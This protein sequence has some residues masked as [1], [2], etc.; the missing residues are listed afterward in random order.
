MKETFQ[1]DPRSL[2]AFRAGIG[3]FIL[4]DL[5]KRAATLEADYTN[6]GIVPSH[7]FGSVIRRLP[8]SFHVFAQTSGE[9]AVLS[10]LAGLLAI[11]LIIGWQTRL[12]SWLSF[13]FMISLQQRKLLIGPAGDSL[14]LSL[15]MWGSML[16][17]ETA[18]SLDAG[19]GRV[20][21]GDYRW[22]DSSNPIARVML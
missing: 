14:V 17:L 4:C 22:L 15:L 7:L 19:L 3:V 1:L 9:V 18:W 16:P 5:V 12:V 20:R 11:A 21:T 6:S 10:V 13:N 8:L 2:A